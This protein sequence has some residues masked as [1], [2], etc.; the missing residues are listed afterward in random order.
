LEP[1]KIE[2]RENSP[3]IDFDFSANSFKI[4]GMSYMEDAA[5]FYENIIEQLKT[6]LAGAN[7]ETIT[8]TFE[9]SYFNSS[10]SRVIF[11]L[12]GL[13]DRAAGSG[14]DVS[15]EWLFD[16]EDIGEE[17]ELLSDDLENASFKLV[18]TN[19]GTPSSSDNS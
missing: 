11:G 6:Y 8:F 14:N 16:D 1:I 17:G 9:M 2:G 19:N 7:G 10:S 12:L 15:I 18:E 3:E 5:G 4:S 13:L